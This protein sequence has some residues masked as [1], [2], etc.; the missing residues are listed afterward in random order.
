L[1]GRK[2]ERPFDIIAAPAGSEKAWQVIAEEFVT[3]DDGTGIVHMAPA[4]G[5]D[6][7]A[8]GLKHGLPM[9][10]PVDD[11]GRFEEGITLVGGMFVKDADKVLL[12]DLKKR[13]LVFRHSMEVHSYPHC[14]RCS[15]P[16][17]YMARDSWYIR[18]TQMKEEM[19]RN[20][21]QVSW[22]PPEV[23]SG[24]FGEWLEGNVDWALSRE[25]Y[26]GTPLPIWVC[27]QNDG[28]R[29]FIGSFADLRARGGEKASA[30]DFDP[31]KPYIDEV[32][33][34][35][36]HCTGTMK[37]T[38][39]VIDVWFD[40]GSMPYAQW[41]YPFENEDQWKRHFPADFICEGVDQTRGWFYSL[42]AISSMLGHGPAFRH[43][44]VKR[45]AA[46]CKRAQDVEIEGQC[47]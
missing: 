14:W 38:P 10:R 27:D 7:Y 6:D 2:Y 15:S 42:M 35:C 41:H 18:T 46:R 19:I 40:S 4:F 20:N 22:H 47:R 25:R 45:P 21:D 16:L 17:I 28:H 1:I 30:A 12:D 13:S 9:L 5:A 37:R 43:V 8:A 36:S 44:I 33:W 31:H 3:S 34:P 29:E 11:A 23:G 26:W 39:E 32:D 24:R